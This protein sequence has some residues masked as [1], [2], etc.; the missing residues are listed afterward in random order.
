MNLTSPLLLEQ[1]L[2]MSIAINLVSVRALTA[3]TVTLLFYVLIDVWEFLSFLGQV[4]SGW[5][6]CAQI[7]E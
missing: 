7:K 4:V 5:S 2:Q 3:C 6:Q 1:M